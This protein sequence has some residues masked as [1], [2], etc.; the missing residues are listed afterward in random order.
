MPCRSRPEPGQDRAHARAV[1]AKLISKSLFEFGIFHADHDG[2]RR[3][4][5]SGQKPTDEQA[6]PDA[7]CEHF[8]QVRQINRVP[9]LA[10]YARGDKAIVAVI[11][12]NL[13][14]TSKLRQAEV[15]SSVKVKI[16]ACGE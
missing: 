2:A 9:H 3:D 14:K 15:C 10:A 4:G 16:N 7:P 8:A 1:C 11:A 12:A 5:K 6:G 13:R